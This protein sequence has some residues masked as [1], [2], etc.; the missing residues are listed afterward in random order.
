M[1]YYPG[2]PNLMDAMRVSVGADRTTV[3]RI[4]FAIP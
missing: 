1:T 4:D 3:A 2:V